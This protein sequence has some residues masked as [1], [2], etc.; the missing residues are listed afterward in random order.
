[1]GYTVV[2]DR[3]AGSAA[4]AEA[5]W[6]TYLKDNFNTGVPYL[7]GST[8]LGSATTSI[9]FSSIGS[10]FRALLLEG[11][12]RS[13]VAG[14]FV[15]NMLRFNSDTGAN[16]DWN[17][18]YAGGASVVSTQNFAQTSI[19]AF[20][21]PGSSASANLFGSFRIW[22]PGYAYAS[23][24]KLV[25][26]NWAHKD[27]TVSAHLAVGKTKGAWRSNSAITSVTLQPITNQFDTG[28]RVSLYGVH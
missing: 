16:Y 26:A 6:D 4:W 11:Y 23:A 1:M 21:H 14:T 3:S 9:T 12:T 2:P 17:D 25:H 19:V 27:S 7:L 8:V 15:N 28:T 24:N 20:K 10:G 18:L 13:T 5:D 22:I